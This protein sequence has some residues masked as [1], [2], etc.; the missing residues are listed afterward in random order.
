MR[1]EHYF[2][3]AKWTR[4][5][6]QALRLSDVHF[7]VYLYLESAPESHAT[8]IYFITLGAVAE[9]LRE[10]RETVAKI[11]FDLERLNLIFW[12]AEASVVWVPCVCQEQFRWSTRANRDR[13]RDFRLTEARRHLD[14]LPNSR[15]VDLFRHR[16][17]A[18]SQG[19]GATQGAT[20]GALPVTTPSYSY[21]GTKLGGL[22][23][24]AGKME[25][26]A[27]DENGLDLAGG[28]L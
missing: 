24:R 1:K 15:L 6:R 5:F 11:V 17:P 25:F 18:F 13:A 14:N 10:E 3:P 20:Q 4:E 7:K 2:P 12:D 8:G 21:L 26:P 19:E 9:V 28:A 23:N 27:Q 22:A 16:W